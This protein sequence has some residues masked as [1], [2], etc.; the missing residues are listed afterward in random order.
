MG[1]KDV[2]NDIALSK[3]Y[4]EGRHVAVLGVG[5]NPHA[6]GTPE[7]DAWERGHASYEAAGTIVI[8]DCCAEPM[9]LAARTL[10]GVVTDLSVTFTVSPA[11][12]CEIDPGDGSG[13]IDAPAGGAVHAYAAAGDYTAIAWLGGVKLDD[14]IVSPTEPAGP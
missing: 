13:R 4:C 3:A 14:T 12:P 6:N 10:S 8:R 5:T 2:P 11:I 9:K 7:A 1:S